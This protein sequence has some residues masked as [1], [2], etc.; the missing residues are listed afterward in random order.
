MTLRRVGLMAMVVSLCRMTSQSVLTF[1]ALEVVVLQIGLGG[2]RKFPADT[3]PSSLWV[4]GTST[5]LKCWWVTGCRLLVGEDCATAL[6]G[7]AA[8]KAVAVS[9]T[10]NKPRDWLTNL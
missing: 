1:V 8:M 10:R 6:D 2:F 4:S 7:P 3:T 9:H 5:P